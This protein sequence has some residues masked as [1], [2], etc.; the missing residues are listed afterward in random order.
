VITFS[1]KKRPFAIVCFSLIVCIASLC[2][3]LSACQTL[4]QFVREPVFSIKSV[5]LASIDLNGVTLLCKVNVENPNPIDIP[6]PEIGWNFFVNE[7]HFLDGVIT[8]GSKIKARKTNV[9]EIPVSFTY[10]GLFGTFQSLKNADEA[11]YN[12]VFDLKF[13]LGALLEIDIPGLQDKT[14]HFEHAGVIPLVKMPKLSGG[15]LK[16]EKLDFTGVEL[17]CSVNVDNPNKFELPFPKMDYDYSLNKNSF[18]K[19]SVDQKGPLAAAAITPVNFKMSINYADLY[20]NV[21][22]LKTVGAAAG[23]L[24]LTTAFAIPAFENEK[25]SV[26]ELPNNLPLLKA[27]TVNF[28]DIKINASLLRPETL[29]KPAIEVNF[30][31]ENNNNFAMNIKDSI[32]DL[33]IN[34]SSL[35]QAKFSNAPIIGANKKTTIP[36]TISAST[37]AVINEV[38]NI[39]KGA[40]FNY[41]VNGNVSLAG[42]N[43]EG[44]LKGIPDINLPY[45]YS[46]KK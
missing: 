26:L 36:L 2:V 40:G 34:N 6:F 39:L 12:I 17:L 42:V 32:C 9:V 1:A 28:K 16:I 37:S 18:I 29:L 8:T 7:N 15:S 33:K 38:T 25:P 4:G 44:D 13:S 21:S 10:L 30:E 23:L 46:G 43:L 14:W 5:E 3:G 27:P 41:A 11:A 20:K 19:T 45:N 31:I 24:A 22:S 35:A